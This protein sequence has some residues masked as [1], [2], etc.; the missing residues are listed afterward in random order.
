LRTRW[1]ALALSALVIGAIGGVMLTP[2][3]AGAVNKDMIELQQQVA[4]ILQNQQD[5]R[6]AMD[7]NNAT[8][9]TLVQQSLDSVSQ[10]N[11]Q[12]VT[13]QKSV[14][15]VQANT[16]S[17]IDSMTQQTQGISDNLQDVQARVGKLAQQLTDM[18]NILQS[19][20]AKVSSGAGSGPPAAEPP[21]GGPGGPAGSYPPSTSGTPSPSTYNAAPPAG[22]GAPY[23]APPSGSNGNGMAPAAMAPV[24]SDTLYHNALRDYTTANYELSRQE[25]ADYIHNFPATDLASNSQFYLGEIAYS[26]GDYKSAI[27][28]YDLVIT[29][30]PQSIKLASA[31]LKK[32]QAENNLR[33]KTAAIRDLREV[34]SKYPGSDESRRARTLLQGMGV[35]ATAPHTTAH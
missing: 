1:F 28:G 3:P 17:R 24:S 32:A 14:Q 21:P 10:M 8:L 26:Q 12:M 25:F 19:I 4:Q 11:G 30:Y 16:G 6:S 18:Q 7:A 9:K 23:S 13:L 31:L 20:D 34:V 27:T 29:K 35:S 5:L 22:A 2:Q 33:E 15:E